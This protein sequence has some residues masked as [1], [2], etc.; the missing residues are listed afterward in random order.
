M[1]SD[2]TEQPF[3]IHEFQAFTETL[4]KDIV[5]EPN[6]HSGILN[7]FTS[8]K[9][10]YP[11]EGS[12]SSDVG[13]V[14][15]TVTLTLKSPTKLN[16]VCYLLETD[17]YLATTDKLTYSNGL[18]LY[19][20]DTDSTI[21]CKE[22]VAGVLFQVWD[23]AGLLPTFLAKSVTFDRWSGPVRLKSVGLLYCNCTNTEF[24]WKDT[25]NTYEAV[26]YAGSVF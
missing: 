5:V 24:L 8:N 22:T 3:I 25:L 14:P 4:I 13:N 17:T 20:T 2:A 21:R 26:M 12:N 18:S 19:I 23:C 1:I 7:S 15:G 11:L 10:L 9:V 6:I 16:F